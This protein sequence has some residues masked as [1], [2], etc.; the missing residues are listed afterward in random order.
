MR[1]VSLLFMA[2]KKSDKNPDDSGKKPDDSGKKKQPANGF[3]LLDKGASFPSAVKEALAASHNRLKT[4]PGVMYGAL[5]SNQMLMLPIMDFG[6]QY[7][8]NGK[9]F[10]SGRVLDI[11]G[12]DGIGK[13]SLFF[14]IC[15]WVIQHNIPCAHLET[16]GKPMD[17]ERIIRCL[18]SDREIAAKIFSTLSF[19]QAFEIEDAADQLETWLR[20]IRDPNSGDAYV[21]MEIPA[22]IGLDTYSKLMNKA[23]A[24]GYHF[25]EEAK[26]EGK[27]VGKSVGK[28][29]KSSKAEE[30]QDL[31]GG[32]N[33][34]HAKMAHAWTRRLPS[35][36]T[37]Y[38][39]FFIIM[40]HQNDKINMMMGA[41]FGGGTFM[42]PEA[43]D[44]NNRVSIGGR[45][46]HQSAAYQLI[47]NREKY[48]WGQVRGERHKV[49]QFINISVGKASYGPVR[50]LRGALTLIPRGDTETHQDLVLDF[51]V[52]LPDALMQTGLKMRQKSLSEITVADLKL[53][54]A[55]PEEI[56]EALHQRPD[57][58]EDLGKRLGL[59]GYPATFYQ[60]P[61]RNPIFDPDGSKPKANMPVP[62][63]PP[64]PPPV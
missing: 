19:F 15:G 57:L 16:E 33:F 36:L 55:S 5:P 21:P 47:I 44:S 48:D 43:K 8:I 38:N 17:Q 26:K 13:T 7:L 32:S 3:N 6:F 41:G 25:Y 9:G 40:R 29:E 2:S 42:S 53:E 30:V 63:P 50:T 51:S 4:N 35:F 11:I 46:F 37:K 58:M 24:A 64:P 34:G 59:L 39:A 56:S 52:G 45:A 49:R 12:P 22:V 54:D 28:S 20:K 62:P 14:T 27:K 31:G 10:L 61:P 1:A 23:E 60:L 18:H